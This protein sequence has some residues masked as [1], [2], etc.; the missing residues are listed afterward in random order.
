MSR[1]ES[2]KESQRRYNARCIKRIPL[3][4]QLS[5]YERIRAAALADGLPV[6]TF[7]KLAITE[8]I[9]RQTDAASG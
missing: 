3:D 8:K 7:I 5:E 6:N 2:A 9:D 4:V 1:S